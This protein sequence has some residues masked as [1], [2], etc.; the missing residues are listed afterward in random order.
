[1]GL[2]SHLT[3]YKV[4]TRKTR[5]DYHCPHLRMGSTGYCS[6]I[7]SRLNIGQSWKKILTR[8]NEIYKKDKLT[9]K[10]NALEAFETYKYRPT[11]KIKDFS[12]KKFLKIK[13]CR[14]TISDNLLA[15]RLLKSTNF[16]IWDARLVKA[17]LITKLKYD[18]VKSKF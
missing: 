14:T 18:S 7:R 11:S 5:S 17:T 6:R 15:W 16:I 4:R 1:M 13:Y 10:Y 9:Q 2:S 12:N 8:L 3:I